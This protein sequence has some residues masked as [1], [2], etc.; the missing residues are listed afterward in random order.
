M[1]S[2]RRKMTSPSRSGVLSKTRKAVQRLTGASNIEIRTDLPQEEK[3][4]N[5]LVVLLDAEVGKGVRLAEYR[6]ALNLIAFA[7]NVSL[8]P[9]SEQPEAIQKLFTLSPRCDDAQEREA[10]AHVER[11]IA[12]KL[13]LFPNDKRWIVSCEANFRRDCLHITAAALYPPAAAA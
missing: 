4:S 2:A 8:L 7:W 12:R 10:I 13:E 9:A 3:I 1:G 11:L 6:M 5:A